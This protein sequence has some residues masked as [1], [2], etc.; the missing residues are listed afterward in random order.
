MDLIFVLCEWHALA[1]LRLHTDST[2]TDLR[3]VTY[4]LG[5]QLRL[6]KDRTC[7]TFDTKELPREQEA[8]ARRTQAKKAKTDGPAQAAAPLRTPLPKISKAFNLSTY[9]LHALGDYIASILRY[10]TSDSY[11]TQVVSLSFLL[12]IFF[13]HHGV[14]LQGELEHRRVKRYYARTNKNKYTRQV[15]RQERRQRLLRGIKRKMDEADAAAPTTTSATNSSNDRPS[16]TFAQSEPLPPT[17]PRQHHHI[18]DSR[19]TGINIPTYLGNHEG[20]PAIRVR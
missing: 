3:S 12:C 4:E 7:A 11:S 6:F 18:S 14:L 8:R 13:S 5:R 16:F 1:K 2:L 17:A 19:R 15:A 10:G 20:D 9:K